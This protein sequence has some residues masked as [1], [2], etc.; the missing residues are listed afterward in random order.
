[1]T[2]LFSLFLT[3][4]C[5]CDGWQGG[6]GSL[7]SGLFFSAGDKMMEIESKIKIL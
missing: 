3:C 6:A 1:M 4:V 7:V 5:V 2:M